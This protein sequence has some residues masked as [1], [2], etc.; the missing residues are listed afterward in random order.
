MMLNSSKYDVAT[1]R[2]ELGHYFQ[3]VF[4]NNVKETNDLNT[5]FFNYLNKSIISSLDNLLINVSFVDN[6]LSTSFAFFCCNSY[7]FS[8]IEFL[9]INLYT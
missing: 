1:I 8:Y 2:H 5:K 9:V 7:I 6:I 3:L 4:N